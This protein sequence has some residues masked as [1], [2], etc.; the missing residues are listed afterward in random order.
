MNS[1]QRLYEILH[2]ASR[3]P[4]K[5]KTQD[6]WVKVL[7]LPEENTGH[8]RAAAVSTKLSAL[9]QEV[10]SLHAAMQETCVPQD[11][12]EPPLRKVE[13]GI[14]TTNLG[15]PWQNVKNNLSPEVLLSLRYN[16]EILG[17]QEQPIDDEEVE[18]LLAE[19]DALQEKLSD[20]SLSPDVR[21]LVERQVEAIRN[22]LGDYRIRG[23]SAIKDA[24]HKAAG[25]V[26]EHKESIAENRESEA[27]SQ[28][29]QIWRRLTQLADSLT[30]ADRMLESGKRMWELIEPAFRSGT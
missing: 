29:G 14:S 20:A 3:E 30:K 2:D 22:A 12:F 17:M 13:A 8:K 10:E 11:V 1:A 28:L 27:V 26:I 5:T 7:K 6:V 9:H 23:A 25:E 16:A 15:A 24:V 18:D 21:A 4:D 19:V